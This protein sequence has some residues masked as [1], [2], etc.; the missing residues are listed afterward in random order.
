MA[1]NTPKSTNVKDRKGDN[2]NSKDRKHIK[3]ELV[4]HMISKNLKTADLPTNEELITDLLPR[5][6]NKHV[7]WEDVTHP[8]VIKGSEVWTRF[9]ILLKNERNADDDKLDEKVKAVAKVKS[10]TKGDDESD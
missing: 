4:E 10:L 7:D 6:A 5:L 1:K 8:R 2:L 3:A 9:L